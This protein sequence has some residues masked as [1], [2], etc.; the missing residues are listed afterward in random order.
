MVTVDPPVTS[1]DAE[2]VERPI[3]LQPVVD[4]SPRVHIRDGGSAAERLASAAI[5][6]H[7]EGGRHLCRQG[8]DLLQFNKTHW[9]VCAEQQI[10]VGLR[11][12]A[13]NI[14][15]GSEKKAAFR[16]AVRLLHVFAMPAHSALMLG[17]P[18]PRAISL[19]N[20]ELW[21]NEN[22]SVEL[23]A[24]RPETGLD[25]VLPFA[26]DPTATCPIFDQTLATIFGNAKDPAS[27]VDLVLRLAGYIIGPDRSHAMVIVFLGEGSNGKSM[28]VK[29][30]QRLLSPHA[31]LFGSLSR[32]TT[33]PAS[34]KS[35]RGK[36]MFVDTDVAADLVWSDALLK[37]LSETTP[38]TIN[39]GGQDDVTFENQA[40]PLLL[41]NSVPGLSDLTHG[42]RRRLVVVP[43][44]RTFAPDEIDAT[45]LD[46][47]VATEMSG[48]LNRAVAG[49]QQL[50]RE[51][52]IIE[53]DDTAAARQELLAAASPIIGFIGDACVV[54]NGVSVLRSAF[55][56]A[57]REWAEA[58]GR[59]VS[60]AATEHLTQLGYRVKKVRGDYFIVGLRL[61]DKPD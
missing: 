8:L 17:A 40:V 53:C 46:R 3:A 32:M 18:A 21:F 49:W 50:K 31:A 52:R 28:L 55:F 9:D 20:G 6:D 45:L 54:E 39:F 25:Y 60:K 19:L 27:V 5:C 61:K 11:D 51:G 24:H 36:R 59:H 7:F 14:G 34:L 23:K 22:G 38:L 15:L 2:C 30:I 57:Y 26:Y 12:I 4:D 33:A 56:T 47:I 42:M 29:I 37:R 58:S 43:F 48:I 35:L 44:D 41:C 13:H 16:E 1:T 10:E